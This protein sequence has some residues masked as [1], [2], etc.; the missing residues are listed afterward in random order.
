ME[1][2]NEEHAAE[3]LVQWNKLPDLARK[4]EIK[5]AIEKLEL[6]SMYYEQKGNDQGVERCEKCILIL[7]KNLNTVDK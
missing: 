7:K 3:M 6:S 2:K 4:R 1:I 5:L